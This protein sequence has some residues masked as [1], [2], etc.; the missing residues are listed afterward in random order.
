MI[1]G[2]LTGLLT[3][4][5]LLTEGKQVTLIEAGKISSGVTGYTTGKVTSQHGAAYVGLLKKHGEA[6]AR[7]Y[8]HAQ[9]SGLELI[10]DLAQ[11]IPCDFT[12]ADA[13]VFTDDPK[14]AHELEEEASVAHALGLPASFSR[15]ADLPFPVSGMVRFENQAW[16]HPR[17]FCV[18][19][20]KS[21][22]A[23]GGSIAEDTRAL[24]VD[25]RNPC[26]VQLEDGE[27]EA[28]AV[29]VATQLPFLASGLFF[30]RT[31][32]MR[33]YVVAGR[34]ESPVEGMY[35]SLD[36]PTRS[37][38]PHRSEDGETLMLIGGGGHPTGRETNTEPEYEQ[39]ETF[40]KEWFGIESE[41]KWSA[42][43]FITQDGLPFVGEISKL[44]RSVYVATGFSKWGMTNAAAAAESITNAIMG[45][46]DAWADAAAADRIAA[47]GSIGTVVSQGVETLKSIVGGNIKSLL[48]SETVDDLPRGHAGIVKADGRRVAAFR[49]E[50]GKVHAVR[51][52]CTHLGCIVAFNEAERS[53]DCPCHGS[54]FG[55]D[56]RV[57]NGPATEDLEAIDPDLDPPN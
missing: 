47:L 32:P 9:Q 5:L 29:V 21:I 35:I 30:A 53:W 39:L 1:G 40:A 10:A 25:G 28:D 33:S 31:K 4:H 36:E 11:R 22:L 19:L 27:I 12:R 46:E 13:H 16:F 38:R 57:L 54:R 24:D 37:F 17:K 52:E 34:T 18:E 26:R 41:W 49:D 44:G 50:D 23:A 55:L 7:T 56:G 20:A 6:V 51:P 45:R 15:T 3:A 2:G 8:A 48:S 42:Q 14:R 43:D